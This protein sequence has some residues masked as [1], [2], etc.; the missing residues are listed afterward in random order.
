MSS[1][2]RLGAVFGL[3]DR[4]PGAGPSVFGLLD[5][6]GPAETSELSTVRDPEGDP[7]VKESE[8]LKSTAL[9]APSP[10]DD[11]RH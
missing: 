2:G 11:G 7:P 10:V 6:P 5:R 3:L 8:Q 9:M 1:A 4:F